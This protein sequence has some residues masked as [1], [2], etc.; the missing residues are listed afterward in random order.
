MLRAFVTTW[1]ATRPTTGGSGARAFTEPTFVSPLQWLSDETG[2]RKKTVANVMRGRSATTSLRIAD[3]L[4]VAIGHPE[5]L[6]D[7]TLEILP[8]VKATKAAQAAC[9]GGSA[10]GA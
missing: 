9:C 2:I 1:T 4:V 6:Q 8:N 3:A 5:A 10:S 7:G